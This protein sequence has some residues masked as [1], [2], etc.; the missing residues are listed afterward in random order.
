MND[1]LTRAKIIQD[2]YNDLGFSKRESKYVL[3]LFLETLSDVLAKGDSVVLQR[4]G[5]FR[6]L[7]KKARPG[8]NLATGEPVTISARKVVVF[9]SSKTWRN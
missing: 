2:M 6:I 5:Q 1:K 4:F 7:D 9:R 3:D 8:R